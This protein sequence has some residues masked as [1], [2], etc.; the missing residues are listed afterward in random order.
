MVEQRVVVT[1]VH[2]FDC[3]DAVLAQ[4]NQGHVSQ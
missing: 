2:V 4:G 3:I 1:V